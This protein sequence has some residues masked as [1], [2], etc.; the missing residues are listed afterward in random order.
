MRDTQNGGNPTLELTDRL[1]VHH[2][3]LQVPPA[4][5]DVAM[6]L[7]RVLL[8]KSH[9]NDRAIHELLQSCVASA[10]SL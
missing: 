8:T 6:S 3:Q 9:L 2:L 7:H 4:G 10:S 1:L 5:S